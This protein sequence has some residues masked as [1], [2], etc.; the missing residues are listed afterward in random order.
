VEDTEAPAEGAVEEYEDPYTKAGLIGVPI[1]PANDP[2]NGASGGG[3]KMAEE[4]P[5]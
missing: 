5:A 2:L 3:E 4:E 1:Y